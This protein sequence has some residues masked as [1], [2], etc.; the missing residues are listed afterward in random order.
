MFSNLKKKF[1]KQP[2]VHIFYLNGVIEFGNSN[3]LSSKKNKIEDLIDDLYDAADKEV[4][5]IILRINSPGGSAGASEE[6]AQTI[7]KVREKNIPVIASVGDLACSGAYMAAACCDYIFAN[8]MSIVG[9][10]GVIMQIPNFKNLSEKIGA[11]MVTIKAGKMKDI[12]NPFKDMTDE[13]KGYLETLTK[14][15]HKDFIKLVT[16]QRQIFDLENMTDGR[17]VDADTAIKNNMIDHFGTF[18]DAL[19]YLAEEKLN[20]EV[21][22]LKIVQHKTKKS[23]VDRILGTCNFNV[24]LDNSVLT[25]FLERR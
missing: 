19:K 17:I 18:H 1:S 8:K 15:S 24:T 2:E 4:D 7:L 23:F 25:N 6:L 16:S 3:S 22:K 11:T 12:G 14:K 13:E 5:G 20:S 21:D 9:S 10:I